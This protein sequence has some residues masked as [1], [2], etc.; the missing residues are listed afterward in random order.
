[1]GWRQRIEI[2]PR[3]VESR[4]VGMQQFREWWPGAVAGLVAAAVA[5]AVAEFVARLVD[6][7]S[8]VVADRRRNHRQLPAFRLRRGDR[9]LRH[10][11]QARTA[12]WHR[13]H[14]VAAGRG[15]GAARDA[16][17]R[18]RRSRLGG[19]RPRRRARGGPRSV[20]LA[21]TG[22]DHRA[23]RRNRGGRDAPLAAQRSD[24]GRPIGRRRASRSAGEAPRAKALPAVRRRRAGGGSGLGAP[25][26][27]PDRPGGRC[28]KRSAPQ[29]CCRRRAPR[30]R[31]HGPRGP[32][33]PHC[34]RQ[35]PA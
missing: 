1:M 26:A 18:D 11:R 34:P 15:P 3:G 4:G 9:N 20:H 28:G 24:P 22:L 16:L 13:R 8:L 35:P 6:G 21:R 30:R 27:A 7:E 14:L 33:P 10:E 25:G 17:P 23:R 5:L 31:R 19:L 12:R 32:R 29:S 2:R